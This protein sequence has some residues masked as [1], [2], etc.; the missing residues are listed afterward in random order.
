MLVMCACACAHTRLPGVIMIDVMTAEQQTSSAAHFLPCEINYTGPAI[1][2]AYFKPITGKRCREATFRGRALKGVDLQLP[3]GYVGAILQDT[4]QA[5]VADGES[6]RW[7][8]RG[9]VNAITLW[10]HDEV[11]H[12]DEAIFKCMRWTAL[13]DII[14]ADH[15]E[16]GPGESGSIS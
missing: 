15:S 3:D 16:E 13:A 14:H 8:H 10:K 12:E 4:V 1:V 5:D 11:P 2:S 6:R 9:S 7:M